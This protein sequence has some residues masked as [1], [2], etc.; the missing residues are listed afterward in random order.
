LGKPLSLFGFSFLSL[1]GWNGKI[2][3]RSLPAQTSSISHQP[4]PGLPR[5]PLRFFQH[6]AAPLFAV[7]LPGLPEASQPSMVPH[8]LVRR[9]HHC[10]TFRA[11]CLFSWT[12]AQFP[13]LPSGS[14]NNPS[15][16][17][18]D[19][20]PWWG[21]PRSLET[22]GGLASAPSFSVLETKLPIHPSL[23][24]LTD[25]VQAPHPPRECSS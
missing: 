4:S 9:I 8:S 15:L 18:Y 1:N 11:S 2:S 14:S 7:K 20:D 22:L 5:N 25:L 19:V 17:G 6:L 24:Y 3:L 13:H 21:P 16:R 10:P 23:L 12:L